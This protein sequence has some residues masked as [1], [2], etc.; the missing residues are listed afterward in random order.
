[1]IISPQQV[2]EYYEKCEVAY[3]DVWDLNNSLAMHYGYWDASVRRLPQSLH[4]MNEVLAQVACVRRGERVLDAGC[5]VGGSAIFLAKQYGCEVEG[6]TLL[7]T[8]V[9]KAIVYAQQRGVSDKVRFSVQDYT[10]TGFEARSFDLVWA[11]ESVCHA[12]DKQAFLQEAYRLLKKGGRLL[13]ADG[14]CTDKALSPKESAL[15]LT[16]TSNWA[17][18]HLASVH[19]FEHKIRQVGFQAVNFQDFTPNIFPS[20]RRLY[21]FAHLA[22]LYGYL[23]KLVGKPY[24]NPH[25]I[26]NTRGAKAQY[27]ALKRGL[28]KYGVFVAKK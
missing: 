2:V 23:C 8:Q 28:W 22:L 21:F 18:P 24:G 15:L 17:I 20:S 19:S 25:T 3:R 12:I 7:E 10:Q 6:I 9:Q 27:Q 11:V 4:R 13:V 5:G 16:W 1:M 26:A 14:F